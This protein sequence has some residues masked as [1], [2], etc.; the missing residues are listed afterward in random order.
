MDSPVGAN[1]VIKGD[2]VC[3]PA[4]WL[5]V[6]K[7]LVLNLG[8]HALTVEHAPRAGIFH[9]LSISSTLFSYLIPAFV[10]H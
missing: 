4:W 3:R 9:K 5:D 6:V 7:F 8:L 1:A 2:F 10:V